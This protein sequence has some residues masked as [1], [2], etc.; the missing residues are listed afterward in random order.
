MNF[1]EIFIRRP[2][3]AT[4]V[5][6]L[7]LLMGIQGIMSMTVRQYPFVQDSVIQ[8]TTSYPGASA[9]LIQ[10][11]ITTPIA[12][13]VSSTENV[14]YV[15]ATSSQGSSTVTVHMLLGSDPDK[16]LTEVVAKTQQV[17]RQLPTDAEDP[18]I[19]KGTASRSRCSISPLPART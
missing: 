11:F 12:Q 6:L 14:D 4:V 10:G 2:V 5:S 9:D 7:M 8:V 18:I 13:A 17:K 19:Q 1:S 3:L 15:S 16:A